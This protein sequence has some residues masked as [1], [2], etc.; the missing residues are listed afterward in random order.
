MKTISTSNAP[1]AIGPYS[2]AKI[3]GNLLFASGQ[4]AI[5]PSSGEIIDGGIE[6]QTTQICENIK[7]ILSE[8]GLTFDNVVKTTC[9][10]HDIADFAAFNAV[11]AEYFTA[12]PARSCVG[13]LDLPKGVLAEVEI[14]AELKA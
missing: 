10:L 6:A 1:A 4:I 11:Y 13:G 8:A 3:T 2:Q 7:A 9:Y 12:K 5:V 14:I